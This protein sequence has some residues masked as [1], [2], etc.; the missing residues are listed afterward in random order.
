M[1]YVLWAMTIFLWMNIGFARSVINIDPSGVAIQGYDAVSYFNSKKPQKG[2]LKFKAVHEESTY[3]FSNEVHRQEFLKNP[4][5]Y[6]PA[7]GGWCAYAVADSKS[8][9]EVDPKSYLIQEGRLL[10]FYNGFLSDTRAK[11]KKDEKEF[12]KRADKNWPEA[13]KTEP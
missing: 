3:L 13:E 2:D 10:L 12:L 6:I 4:L 8:K 5:K 9:I 11:W 7:Y 1:K